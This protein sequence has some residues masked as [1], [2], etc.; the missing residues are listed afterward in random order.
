MKFKTM[1]GLARCP[2][3]QMRLG[4]TANF[5]PIRLWAGPTGSSKSDLAQRARPVRPV[6]T[7]LSTLLL[8]NKLENEN[9]SLY[10]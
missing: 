6:P 3:T 8:M 7:L 4:W 9:C 2:K 10:I 1:D 5:Q